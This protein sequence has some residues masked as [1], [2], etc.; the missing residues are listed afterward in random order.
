MRGDRH[1]L[2]LCTVS[3]RLT[4]RCAGGAQPALNFSFS[5]GV[6]T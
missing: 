5:T 4:A 2:D 3:K 6:C 1:R